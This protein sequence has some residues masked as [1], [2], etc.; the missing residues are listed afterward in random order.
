[1]SSDGFLGYTEACR[2]HKALFIDRGL[3]CQCPDQKALSCAN[4]FK[5]VPTPSR[6]RMASLTLRPLVH[7]ELSFVQGDIRIYLNL[8]HSHPTLSPPFAGD[9][10]FF[11]SVDYRFFVQSPV[12]IRHM[13]LCVCIFK[14]ILLTN[15]SVFLPMPSDFH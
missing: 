3:H 4:G 2:L 5:P 1:M 12:S 14:L 10:V 13:D 9:V 6:F 7:L 8:T 15:M 11:S